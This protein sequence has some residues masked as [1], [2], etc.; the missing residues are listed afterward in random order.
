MKCKV[1]VIVWLVWKIPWNINLALYFSLYRIKR[2][3]MNPPIA[4]RV[5]KKAKKNRGPAAANKLPQGKIFEFR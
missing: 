4:T 5:G 2:N 3:G 1:L